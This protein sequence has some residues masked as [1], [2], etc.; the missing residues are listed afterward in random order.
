MLSI[1]S[2]LEGIPPLKL[3]PGRCLGC[4]TLTL[5]YSLPY[6]KKLID[7]E[8]VPTSRIE[9][10]FRSTPLSTK[11]YVCSTSLSVHL[12]I[13]AAPVCSDGF[14]FS[15]SPSVPKNAWEA[16]ADDQIPNGPLIHKG[17][18]VRWSD[19]QMARDPDIWGEDCSEYK[20]SR[21]IDEDG[22]LRRFSNWKFHAFKYVHK[23]FIHSKDETG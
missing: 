2:S 1:R 4:S 3:S 13:C 23:Y 14:P 5:V 11:V 8:N 15:A 19:W 6:E 7:W 22:N 21:W 18:R 17:D 16:L 9:I 12:I 10:S 20:P